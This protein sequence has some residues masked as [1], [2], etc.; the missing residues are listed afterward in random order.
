MGFLAPFVIRGKILIQEMWAS[1]L[2]W[3]EPLDKEL[4][5]KAKQWLSEMLEL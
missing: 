1:G 4:E 2:D 3:D 5:T